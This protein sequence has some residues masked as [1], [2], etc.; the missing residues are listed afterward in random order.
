MRNIHTVILFCNPA[1]FCQLFGG[2]EAGRY[3]FQ[4]GADPNGSLFHSLPDK[5][6]HRIHLL[7]C[8]RAVV[9][10][11]SMDPDGCC[12][13]KRSDVGCDTFLFEIFEVFSQS[14]PLNIIFYIPL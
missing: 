7:S 12:A 13:H 3:V 11:H 4:C 9:I 10:S 6:L 8:W 1:E 5:Q 2:G 14:C